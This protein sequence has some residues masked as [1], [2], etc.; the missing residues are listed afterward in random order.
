MI[1]VYMSVSIE[2]PTDEVKQLNVAGVSA[3]MLRNIKILAASSGHYQND[4]LLTAIRYLILQASREGYENIFFD[5]DLIHVDEKLIY[6]R[7]RP[8]RMAAT[9]AD[10]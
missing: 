5:D 3:T 7:Q 6:P 4:V 8:E 1:G 10:E 9:G 2:Y